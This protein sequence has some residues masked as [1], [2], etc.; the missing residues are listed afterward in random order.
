MQKNENIIS[1]LKSYVK[2]GSLQN[3]E[4]VIELN[5]WLKNRQK[6]IKMIRYDEF[7]KDDFDIISKAFEKLESYKSIRYID[8]QYNEPFKDVC[9]SYIAL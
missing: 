7:S 3:E 9:K 1:Q 5:F 6:I 8:N 4:P 2:N